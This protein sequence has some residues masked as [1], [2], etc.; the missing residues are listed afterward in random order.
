MLKF[1]GWVVH[2]VFKKKPIKFPVLFWA[3][4]HHIS[5]YTAQ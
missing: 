4:G 2:L 5:R 1:S 3:L